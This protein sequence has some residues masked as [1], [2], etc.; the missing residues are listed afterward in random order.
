MSCE[1]IYV[2]CMLY[3]MF[4]HIHVDVSIKLSQVLNKYMI[5]QD[6]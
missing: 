6:V 1:R 3:Y 2:L 5:V 4:W